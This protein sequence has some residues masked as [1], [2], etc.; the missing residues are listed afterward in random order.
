ME[1]SLNYQEHQIPILN[2]WVPKVAI[3]TESKPYSADCQ[4]NARN[5]LEAINLWL[6]QYSDN[7]HTFA[8][9]SKEAKRL[10]LWC[11]YEQGK[12]LAQ[13]KVADFE[14]YFTFLKN[15]P[16]SW[17]GTR[18]TIKITDKQ[19][20]RK[21][22]IGPLNQTAFNMAIRIINS[23]MNYLV[24]ADYLRTNPLKLIKKYTKFNLDFEAQKYKVKSRMLE[25][26]E[27]E[28]IQ[29]TLNN[30]PEDTENAIDN[31]MRTQF[32][33]AILYL[34]GLR[35]H[36]VANSTWNAFRQMDGNWWFFIQGKGGKLGHIPVNEQLLNFVK[37]YRLHLGKTPFPSIDETEHLL[38]SKKTKKPLQI[39]QLYGLVKAIGKEAA[40]QFADLPNK[41]Q[42]LISL[43][44][45]WLRH[46]SASHQ[47]K[48]GI[49]ATVIQANHRHA[50]SQTTQLYL[51][52]EDLLR[53]NEM[54]KL[55]MFLQPKIITKPVED[56]IYEIT[57]TIKGSPVSEV[58]NLERLLDAIEQQVFKNLQW[59]LQKE[60]RAILLARYKQLLIYKQPLL[61]TYQLQN[62]KIE[63]LNYI[64]LA[65]LR[66]AEVRL[67][68]CLITTK[69]INL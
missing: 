59:Q 47:D 52:A 41:K 53:V 29:E 23:L 10:L 7:K 37:S 65:I 60:N 15:P 39:S 51:H 66:E 40:K 2:G 48:L 58:F 11:I 16:P 32:L 67:F 27:W 38:K 17:C 46:L 34:L 19:T 36:E 43:S 55:Q 8:A 49:P 68:T 56:S 35:I 6:N 42:K 54:Q 25:L 9:Y 44:P 18:K 1:L 20:N 63:E 21:P 62:I 31:K 61:I 64:N 50:S 30:M 3:F 28:A 57:L 14:S 45:H 69:S 24:E 22:F 4:I 13:L 33:F 5:D 12:T 26:D